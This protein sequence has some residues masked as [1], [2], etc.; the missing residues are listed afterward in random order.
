MDVRQV[1]R[2]LCVRYVLEGSVRRFGDRIRVTVQLIDAESGCHLWAEK[3]DHDYAE[4]F[5]LQD[6]ITES[7][8]AA[9]EPGESQSEKAGVRCESPDQPRRI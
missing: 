6:G 5:A 9:I 8:V 4:V 7:V 1:G 2:E 3:Y